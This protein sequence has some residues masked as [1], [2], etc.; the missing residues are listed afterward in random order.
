VNVHHPT[1]CRAWVGFETSIPELGV[2]DPVV[3]GPTPKTDLVVVGEVYATT[4]TDD[5]LLIDV[6]RMEAPMVDESL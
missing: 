4:E 1:E 6:V 3:V 5:R 2:G